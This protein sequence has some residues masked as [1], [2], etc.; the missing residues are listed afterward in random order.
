[1]SERGHAAVELALGIG[2]LLLPVALAVLAFGPW[3][4]RRVLAEAAAAEGA[5]LLAVDLDQLAAED[6]VVRMAGGHGAGVDRV[7]LGWC[8]A[9]PATAG[10]GTGSCA[11][12]R[13]SIVGLEVEVWVPLVMTPWGEVGGVWVA[14]DHAE[15]IDVYRSLP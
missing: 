4:E 1:M 3:S 13:G 10:S 8:G 9:R 6:L 5:R 7:R 15:P 12:G 2:V 14:A 11:L